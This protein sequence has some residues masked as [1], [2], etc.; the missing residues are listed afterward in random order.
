MSS[1]NKSATGPICA[2][3]KWVSS[4][5]AGKISDCRG[6]VHAISTAKGSGKWRNFKLSRRSIVRRSEVRRKRELKGRRQD[7]SQS[8]ATT[9]QR[10][11][12][13]RNQSFF[14]AEGSSPCL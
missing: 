4:S 2:G 5:V 14:G 12:G 11:W 13:K 7:R 6:V 3:P 8:R 10:I 9:E 1:C